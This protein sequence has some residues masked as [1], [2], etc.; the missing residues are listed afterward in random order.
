MA[1]RRDIEPFY[2][3]AS[4]PLDCHTFMKQVK[5]VTMFVTMPAAESLAG[6]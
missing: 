1:P 2:R 5:F 6:Y 3:E 4:D